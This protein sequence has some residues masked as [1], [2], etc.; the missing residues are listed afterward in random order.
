MKNSYVRYF[1]S[2]RKNILQI[3]PIEQSSMRFPSSQRLTILHQRLK[4]LNWPSKKREI[5]QMM[6][7]RSAN[8]V[9]K[10]LLRLNTKNPKLTGWLIKPKN[11]A[12]RRPYTM[13]YWGL[14]QSS[15]GKI[16]PKIKGPYRSYFPML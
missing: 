11:F 10:R 13:L 3:G 4:Q 8:L 12:K 9:Y 14:F 6:K 2:S 1:R 15:M 7:W 16:K 5:S